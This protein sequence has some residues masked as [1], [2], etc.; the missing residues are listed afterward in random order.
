MALFMIERQFKKGYTFVNSPSNHVMTSQT[1]KN[2]RVEVALMKG[3]QHCVS[4]E[5]KK[6]I[7]ILSDN[8]ALS[9]SGDGSK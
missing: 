2:C 1:W 8:P 5:I 7:T 3:Q 4:A 9:S 6:M